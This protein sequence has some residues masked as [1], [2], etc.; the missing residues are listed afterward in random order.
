MKL[1]NATQKIY[2]I[3]VNKVQNIQQISYVLKQDEG[4]GNKTLILISFFLL[5]AQTTVDI[6]D[7]QTS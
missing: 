3:S 6:T 1:R 4:R 7:L 5:N 2:Q